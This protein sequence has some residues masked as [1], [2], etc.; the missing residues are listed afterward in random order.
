MIDILQLDRAECRT[1]RKRR[2][3]KYVRG[4]V[5]LADLKEDAPFIYREIVRQGLQNSAPGS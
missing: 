5:D 2:Y 3:E 4:K 1:M